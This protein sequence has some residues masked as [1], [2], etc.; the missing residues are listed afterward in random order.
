[1]AG[2]KNVEHLQEVGLFSACTDR[3]LTQV[4]RATDEVSVPAGAGREQ[5]DLLQVLDVLVASHVSTF[6]ATPDRKS[7]V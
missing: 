5:P 7:V 3:E 2:N 6:Q 1:M 4:A